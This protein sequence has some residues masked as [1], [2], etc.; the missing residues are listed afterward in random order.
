MG[1]RD[2]TKAQLSELLRERGIGH[3]SKATKA[4]MVDLLE[5]E[6][7]ATPIEVEAVEI[8]DQIIPANALAIDAEALRR[9]AVGLTE[10]MDAAAT[11]LGEYDVDDAT[12]DAMSVGDIKVCEEGIAT[13][14]RYVDEDRKE[15][16]RMLTAPKKLVDEKCRELT[17]PLKALQSRYAQARENVYMRGYEAQYHECCIAN[18]I[19]A[20]IDAVPFDRFMEMHPRWTART[21]NPVKTQERIAEEV[22]RVAKDWR[23]LQSMRG[24]MRF[25]DDAEIAFFDTLD[26]RAAIGRNDER[27]R[28]QERI[29]A[30][31]AE[32]EANE[33]WRVQNAPGTRIP[34]AGGEVAA[35]TRND[36]PEPTRARQARKL[37]R[38]SAWLT[39]AEVQSLREWKNACGIGEGWTFK[40]E[41]NG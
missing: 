5:A 41:R 18:G 17:E 1:Y 28:G 23:T 20:L 33:R 10:T 39:D 3:P 22:E 34:D 35:E 32:R 27:T 37:Y 30:M 9:A 26:L 40:E 2:M 8:N 24:S 11:A 25:Y 31:N 19:E 7:L 6:E 36:A 29:D 16:T 4:E 12:L 14:I 38:F 15:L 13:A 21:A